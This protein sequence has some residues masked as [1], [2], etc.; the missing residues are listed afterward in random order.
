MCSNC[1][2]DGHD[3]TVTNFSKEAPHYNCYTWTFIRSFGKY[4]G[5]QFKSFKVL[6]MYVMLN[7]RMHFIEL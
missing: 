4:E 3:V 6:G 2:W 1:W 7:I 5:L